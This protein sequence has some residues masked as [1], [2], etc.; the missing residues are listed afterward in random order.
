MHSILTVAG[1]LALIGLA[2]GERAASHVAKVICIAPLVLV[3]YVTIDK[4]THGRLLH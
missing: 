2:F 3:I 4:L 1:L